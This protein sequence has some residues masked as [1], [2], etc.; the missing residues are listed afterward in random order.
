[1]ITEADIAE[2][3]SWRD[4]VL[5]I[6]PLTRDVYGPFINWGAAIAWASQTLEHDDWALTLL[7]DPALGSVRNNDGT[8]RS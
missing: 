8:V 6:V 5:V 2:V 4:R 1:M 3:T 7:N